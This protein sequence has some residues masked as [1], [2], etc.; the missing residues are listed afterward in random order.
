MWLSERLGPYQTLRIQYLLNDDPQR[1]KFNMRRVRKK[2]AGW[3][4]LFTE[5]WI[6]KTLAW[7]ENE[8]HKL[9]KMVWTKLGEEKEDD[10]LTEKVKKGLKQ[11]E[12]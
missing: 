5:K 4:A 1:Q 2:M 9:G 6:G 10:A 12:Y 7:K 3:N 8:D 11:N